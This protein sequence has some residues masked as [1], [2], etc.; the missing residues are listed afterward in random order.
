MTWW[1][2]WS[3]TA[4]KAENVRDRK[5]APALR[6]MV[7]MTRFKNRRQS[8]LAS[9]L[10]G[11]LFVAAQF[12]AGAPLQP[13]SQDQPGQTAFTDDV[14]S[15]LLSRITNGLESRNQKKVLAA[16]DLAAMAD[17][18]LFKQQIV[19]FMSHTESIRIHINLVRTSVDA[20]KGTAE[21]DVEMETAPRDSNANPVH[22]QERLVFT[23]ENTP[24]GWK[25][26]DVQPRPFFSLQT[27]R[28][29]Q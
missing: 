18:E 12:A 14:A 3:S 9:A 16:F 25:F 22:K 15:G 13:G 8:A 4:R 1:C 21:A 6:M 19:S 10:A 20:G 28:S 7:L 26:I 24:A 17:G 11:L 5:R 27:S 2:G 23:A 29:E